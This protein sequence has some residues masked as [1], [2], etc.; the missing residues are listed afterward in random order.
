MRQLPFHP[1]IYSITA[2]VQDAG[3][4]DRYLSRC[5]EL[6]FDHVLV[7][8]ASM[9]LAAELAEACARRGVRLLIDVDPRAV[10]A[11]TGQTHWFGAQSD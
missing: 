9:H 8:A 1:R 6:G 4:F 7:P 2:P 5:V 10:Q 3:R 11:D